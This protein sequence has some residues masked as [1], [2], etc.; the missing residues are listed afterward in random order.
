MIG[1]GSITRLRRGPRAAAAAGLVGL[2]AAMLLAG[3]GSAAAA[4][5]SWTLTGSMTVTRTNATATLLQNGEVLVAGGNSASNGALSSAELYNPATGTWALTGSMTTARYEQTAT[6]LQNGEVLVVGGMNDTTSDLG[7]AEVYNPAAGTWAA[8]GSMADDPGAGGTAT[9]LPNGTVLVAG[10]C[11]TPAAGPGALASA[12]IYNPATNSW[13]AT[14][15][16]SIGRYYATAT[17][18]GNGTV[19]VVGGDNIVPDMMS[20]M[21]SS[22]LTS[23]EIYNPATGSWQGAGNSATGHVWATASLLPSGQV[24]VAGGSLSGCCGGVTGADLYTPSTG[25]W[26]AAAPMNTPRESAAAVVLPNGTVLMT[27]GYE[28]VTA[29]A[30]LA[31]TEIYQPS[32]NTWTPGPNLNTGRAYHTATLLPNG[33]V[34]V[35][36][37]YDGGALATAELYSSGTTSPPAPAVTGVTPASGPAAGG[38]AVTVTGSNL[39]GGSVAFGTTAATGVSCAASSCT[40]T[41]PAG[42]GTVNVTVTTSGGTSAASSAGQFSYAAAP[43]PAPAVTGVT[44]ASGPAAGGTAVTVAG[45]NLAGGSVAF[46]TAAAAG[47]S[48]AASSCTA[49]SPAGAGTVNVTVTTTTGTSAASTAS[50]FSY[51]AAPPPAPAV[52]GISPAAGPPA[53]GTAVTVTGASL[54]GGTVAFG[55]TPAT[56]V[57]CSATSCTATSPAGTGTVNVTVTTTSGTSAASTADQFAYTTAPPP[58]NLIPDPGFETTAVPADYW[59]SALARSQAVVHSGSW[60]LAQTLQSSGGGWDLDS[61]PSWCVPLSTAKTYTAGIWVRSTAT[62][63]VNLSLDLLDSGDNY[64][65]SA[66]GP[67]VTLVANTWTHLT[68]T[69]IKPATGEVF[70]GMEPDFL[71]GAK[72]TIIY[73]DDMT[74]TSP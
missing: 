67:N 70:G 16:M 12:Q 48:C 74:L 8:T 73:W 1:T 62:V 14:G 17:L 7:T 25:A 47:V 32:T 20:G 37:G 18:L 43:P 71:S 11:C 13:T 50:Q 63:K 64:M 30:W 22:P 45:S 29:T 51:T 59:G 24:L 9:L 53:G 21:G 69:G 58:A 54:A 41:S 40:A 72:G 39:A 26:Q 56:G 35:A 65:D 61:N 27:G 10:G 3:S 60:S 34:L 6:L 49:T 4:T 31:S 5:G 46:G 33:Q 68:V 2:A 38:T 23:A 42:T 28:G 55:T 57:S 44:P 66:T 52:T 15:S 36:G 19:L